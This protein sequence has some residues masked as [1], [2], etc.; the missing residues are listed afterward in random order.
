MIFTFRKHLIAISAL[1]GGGFM[2][3]VSSLSES[4]E[5][6]AVAW[7]CIVALV[8]VL[9]HLLSKTLPAR[10]KLHAT[11]MK[12]AREQY[13]TELREARSTFAA[14]NADLL[15][16]LREARHDRNAAEQKAASLAGTN[17]Q[18]CARCQGINPE[19]AQHCLRCGAPL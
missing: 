18:T 1:L 3:D 7:A 2:A 8:W 19:V 11:E 13:G 6:K 5:S 16:E 9:K 12:E 4:L 15:N 14:I 17:P 10:E